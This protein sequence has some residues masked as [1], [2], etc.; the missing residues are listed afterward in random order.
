MQSSASPL[1]ATP[2][3]LCISR[4]LMSRLGS[5]TKPRRGKGAF[6][7]GNEQLRGQSDLISR[8][9][10][11]RRLLMLRA[12][13][14]GI[15]EE[16]SLKRAYENRHETPRRFFVLGSSLSSECAGMTAELVI[17]PS[18]FSLEVR[19][20]KSPRLF[21]YINDFKLRCRKRGIA[22]SRKALSQ[23]FFLPSRR[24]WFAFRWEVWNTSASSFYF[25][26]CCNVKR[27]N[28]YN[29]WIKIKYLNI[30][31]Y[32]WVVS[33]FLNI[34][35]QNLREIKS[36]KYKDKTFEYSCIHTRECKKK[37]RISLTS[38]FTAVTYEIHI[39]HFYF[40]SAWFC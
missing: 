35:I 36:E 22:V 25:S 11:A 6:W 16:E 24:N 3:A 12:G 33:Y 37:I 30:L 32:E 4:M 18:D 14:E 20:L 17:Q 1:S 34:F 10:H 13:T 27:S 29:R 8:E 23:G 28:Y 26:S 21:I 2:S 31:S 40:E 38:L 39:S 15:M 5:K 7:T 9:Q 19:S